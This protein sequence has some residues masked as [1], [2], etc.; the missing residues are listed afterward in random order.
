MFKISY[1]TADFA[2]ND[3]PAPGVPLV[4]EPNGL[5]FRVGTYWLFDMALNKFAATETLRSYAD[6]L[7][8]WLR[9][10]DANGWDWAN[11]HDAHLN[12]YRRH[13]LT[14]PS[15]FTDRPYARSTINGR[16][17]RIELFYRFAAQHR[18]IAHYPFTQSQGQ[19]GRAEWQRLRH[20]S[21][22]PAKRNSRRHRAASSTSHWVQ[23]TLLSNIL[24]SLPSMDRLI[25]IWIALSGCRRHEILALTLSQITKALNFDRPIVEIELVVTKGSVPRRIYVPRSVVDLTYHFMTGER[26]Q[27]MREARKKGRQLRDHDKVWFTKRGAPIAARTYSEHILN[28]SRAAGQPIRLHDLRHTYAI[29][30]L[31]L[32][33]KLSANDPESEINSLQIVRLLL[34]HA[35]IATTTRYLE[36]M[37][38]SSPILLRAIEQWTLVVSGTHEKLSA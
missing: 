33:K 11:V 1:T 7:A 32:L 23:Q 4:I 36:S 37:D 35:S 8:D 3:L 38:V 25:T 15:S 14:E 24:S 22:G 10:C 20:N 29:S 26:A 5:I 27:S 19:V 34:G 9:T 13:M 31:L 12:A 6:A 28:A 2:P 18:H 21:A 30:M 17:I 16:L